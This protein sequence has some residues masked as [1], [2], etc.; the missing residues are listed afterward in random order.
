MKHE[1]FKYI[2]YRFNRGSRPYYCWW[3]FGNAKKAGR[4]TAKREARKDQ[5]G[6]EKCSRYWKSIVTRNGF[7][8]KERGAEYV[9]AYINDGLF[10]GQFIKGK[11]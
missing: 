5:I 7:W 9:N 1:C 4:R 11:D 8:E 6:L 10:R 2:C 3:P